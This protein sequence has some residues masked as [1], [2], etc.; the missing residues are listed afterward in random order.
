M[1]SFSVCLVKSEHGCLFYCCTKYVLGKPW[2]KPV[3][4]GTVQTMVQMVDSK[5]LPTRPVPKVEH[6]SIIGARFLKVG[7]PLWKLSLITY[8]CKKTLFLIVEE[9][10]CADM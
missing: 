10:R 9:L 2:Q 5:N 3:S 6:L 7:C 1:V 4:A 8:C